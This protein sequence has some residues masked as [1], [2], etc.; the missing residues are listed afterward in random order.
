MISIIIASVDPNLLSEIKINIDKTIGVSYEVIAFENKISPKGLGEIYNLGASRAQFDIV[1]FVHEDVRFETRNWGRCV[2]NAFRNNERLGLLG[3]AGCRYKTLAPSSWFCFEGYDY[4][5]HISVIQEFKYESNRLPLDH[6]LAYE[7]SAQVPVVCLDGVL[8]ISKKSII[9]EYG[10]DEKLL[11]GF[12]GYDLDIS[13][14]IGKNYQVVATTEFA[15]THFSEGKYDQ[16]WLDAA[17]AVHRKWKHTFPRATIELS[18]RQQVYLE[19]RNMR[20][21]LH[22]MKLLKTP[23]F[24]M[25]KWLWKSQLYREI[26]W[27]KFLKLHKE[28]VT[29][30]DYYL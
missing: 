1:C 20:Y 16:S 29:K 19:K 18:K 6:T 14:A 2:L 24:K 26:G 10:F 27:F 3:V 22:L 15:I 25:L 11:S 4:L 21:F 28:L 23:L 12:H 7:K 5:H 30:R 9:L 13:L 17:M 8:L